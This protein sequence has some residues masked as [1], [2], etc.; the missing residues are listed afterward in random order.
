M[1]ADSGLQESVSGLTGSNDQETADK[2]AKSWLNV[3]DAAVYSEEQFRDWM[4]PVDRDAV[5][6]RRVLELGCGSG[7]LLH[8]VR[9]WQPA[10]LVGI[11]LG[12]SVTRAREL[13][14]ASAIIE[15]EDLIDWPRLRDRH[16]EFD[17]S[18][19]IGVLHHLK[20]PDRGFESLLRM[21]RPG[22]RFHGWVYAHEGNA[23][24]RVLVEP[25][26]RIAHHLP[27]A[28]NKYGIAMPL[29]VP[30]YLY[31]KLCSV[32]ARIFPRARLPMQNYMLWISK[33][34]FPFHHHVAF[35]QLVTPTTHYV[36]R[37]RVEKWLQDPRIEPGSVYIEHRNGNGWKF[38]GR[39]R[40]A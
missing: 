5:E 27:W 14:G 4:A 23:V 1:P 33:R 12:D 34:G 18:Y 26:R 13:L 10:L 35:D 32:V 38:G 39:R 28:V 9:G 25:V 22:G 8:H 37:S 24:V 29:A 20:E 30:F 40:A 21:T 17:F 36:R 6:G 16:G 2:F 15:R 31:S 19:C 11:D 7:A 3:S